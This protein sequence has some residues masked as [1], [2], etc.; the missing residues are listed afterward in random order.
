MEQTRAHIP[1]APRLRSY[2][3]GLWA[4]KNMGDVPH[5]L[6]ERE[7]ARTCH[8]S[9]DTEVQVRYLMLYHPLDNL[10]MLV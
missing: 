2:D 10:I 5:L 1:P 9:R 3:H 6:A 7:R 8:G 4:F